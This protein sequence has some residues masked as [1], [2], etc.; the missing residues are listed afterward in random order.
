NTQGVMPD[1]IPGF[2][3]VRSPALQV[4]AVAMVLDEVTHGVKRHRVP[5]NHLK[6]PQFSAERL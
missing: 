2:V 1:V 5:P 4:F 6:L 3:K